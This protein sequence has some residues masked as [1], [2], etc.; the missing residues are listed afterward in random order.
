MC[1]CVRVRARVC[2]YILKCQ[3]KW[4]LSCQFSS[5]ADQHND[6]HFVTPVITGCH[7]AHTRMTML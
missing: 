7:K 3:F 5:N 1:V 6:T 2:V 4:S